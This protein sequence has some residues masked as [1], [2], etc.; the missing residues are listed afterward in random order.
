MQAVNLGG[1]DGG[2]LKVTVNVM[3]KKQPEP[4]KPNE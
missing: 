1:A 3:L 2:P 4:V